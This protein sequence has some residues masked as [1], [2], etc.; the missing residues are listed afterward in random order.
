[1]ETTKNL[2]TN[3]FGQVI[4]TSEQLREVILCGKNI[5][6]STVVDD[7]EVELYN[8]FSK[9]VLLSP[10]VF[11]PEPS[12][13]TTVEDFLISK[14]REWFIPDEYKKINVFE[15]LVKKCK[16]DEELVR[17]AE[18][19]ILYEE[20]ELVD[21]LKLFIFLVDYSRKN[22]FLWGVG[23]GSST[24]SYILY[25]IGVHRVNSLKYGLEIS[26]YLK[27]E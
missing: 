3:K 19:Y 18:E 17:V 16:T 14:S 1:M 21:L 7:E 13:D 2:E 5:N 9:D 20:K 22:K 10:A 12:N 24:C 23:R 8:K 26:E 25:L 27:K 6:H 15:W 11:E 4:V